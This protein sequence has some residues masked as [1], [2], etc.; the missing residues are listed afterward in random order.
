MLNLA[1]AHLREREDGKG[2]KPLVWVDIGGGTGPFILSFLA[3]L[4]INKIYSRLEH[5]DYG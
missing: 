3:R 1:A 4:K 5:R 2:R